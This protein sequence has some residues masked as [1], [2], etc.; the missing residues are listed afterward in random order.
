[1][2]GGPTMRDL[3]TRA[4]ADER[5]RFLAVG[6]FNTAFGFL[7][8]VVI[9]LTLGAAL[10]RAGLSLLA[11]ILTVLLS[12]L[13]AS[14]VAFILYRRLV[15]RVEGKVIVDFLRFQA[16]YLVP[17]LVNL[18]VLPAVV[19]LGAPRIPAQAV[20]IVVTTIVSYVGHK[21]F[22]FRRSHKPDAD[23]EPVDER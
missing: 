7:L 21:F 2:T 19:H 8:F 22:S 15:F 13:V 12:H 16:V 3:V 5:I 11:S 9:D 23:E 1:M 6:G 4:F 18:V 20:I 14:I 10:D 17:L